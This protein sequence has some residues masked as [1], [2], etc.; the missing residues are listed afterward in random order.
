MTY[1]ERRAL[2]AVAETFFPG[3]VRLGFTDAF[4]ETFLPALTSAERL[5]LR[6]LLAALA[7]SG[8]T[9][10]SAERSRAGAPRLVRQP[11]PAS[12]RG[13]P[14][15]AQRP[16]DD[17]LHAARDAG[18]GAHRL[19]RAARAHADDEPSARDSAR[20]ARPDPR[21]R[22]LRGGLGRGRRCGCG[23]AGGGGARRA[24]ARGRRALRGGRLRRRRTGRL[25]PP[26][27]RARH[28]GHGRP[29]H[30]HPRR[31]LPRRRHGR[32]LHDVVPDARRRAR[33]VGR[34]LRDRRLHGRT[35][36]GLRA[37]RRQ[38]RPQHAVHPGAGRVPRARGARLARGAD[39]AQ[40]PRLR[41]GPR[42]R[43][44]RLRLP[45]GGEAVDRAHVARRRPG[46]RRAHPRAHA[47]GARPGRAGRRCR[48]PGPHRRRARRDRP[49]ARGRRCLR[50]A[51][52]A[53]AARSAPG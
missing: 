39:A 51:R 21:L 47:R 32:Q 15:A 25:P 46:G 4:L 13:F 12:A 14:G 42:V 50:L 37:D 5:R 41:P 44:L 28:D 17:R 53:R 43:L 18:L 9:R 36:Q 30:R 31:G 7:A 11:S 19:P 20:R 27:P 49:R 23:R 3:A 35:G 40:R 2:D 45:A 6:A 10:L 1:A 33:G 22:R 34:R 16:A 29:G 8:F 38:H 52:D 26:L 24:R 48:C